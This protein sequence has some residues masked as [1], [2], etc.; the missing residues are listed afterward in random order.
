MRSSFVAD[1]MK[2][3]SRPLRTQTAGNP[4]RA[5]RSNGNG[6]FSRLSAP[7]KPPQVTS[8]NI[9]RLVDGRVSKIRGR[10]SKKQHVAEE[11]QQDRRSMGVSDHHTSDFEAPMDEQQSQGNPERPSRQYKPNTWAVCFSFTTTYSIL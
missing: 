4:S 9:R 1:R 8:Y 6:S 2:P 3:E 10:S 7:S 5:G 11:I